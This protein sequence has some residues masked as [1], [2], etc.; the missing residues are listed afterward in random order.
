MHARMVALYFTIDVTK[1]S[2]VTGMQVMSNRHTGWIM[3]H[4]LYQVV[5]L[6][7]IPVDTRF[8][9]NT[10]LKKADVGR[11]A[12][13]IGIDESRLS[14][15]QAEYQIHLAN[16]MKERLSELNV[17]VNVIDQAALICPNGICRLLNEE[18]KPVYKDSGHMRPFFVKE[19][20]DV[21][22][23]YVLLTK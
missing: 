17:N 18:G 4:E 5:V 22:D 1:I 19:Y 3:N 7:D 12:I 10:L 9:P 13:P 6:L 11:R 14:F 21:L 20:M 2:Q 8:D 16:K 15:A 23:P